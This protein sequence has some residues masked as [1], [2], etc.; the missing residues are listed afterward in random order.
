MRDAALDHLRR[1]TVAAGKDLSSLVKAAELHLE[2]D[3][4]EEAFDLATQAR[5]MGFQAK[6]QRI[7]GLVHLAKHDYQ[8]AAFHLER[9]DLDAKAFAGLIQA[10]LRLGDLDAAQRRAEASGAARRHQQENRRN[11]KRGG[12]PRRTA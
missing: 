9:C 10:H 5:E 1:Y 6:A 12:G 3:R 7:L 2:L 4:Y 8:Q 11:E